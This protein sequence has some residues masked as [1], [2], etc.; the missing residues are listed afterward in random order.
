MRMYARHKVNSVF[1]S[2]LLLLLLT[3]CTSLAAPSSIESQQNASRDADARVAS[4]PVL[5]GQRYFDL[6]TAGEFEQA[7]EMWGPD[8][9]IHQSGS[10]RFEQSMLAY[11]AFHGE[12]TGEARTEGAAGTLYAEVPIRVSGARRGEP[13]SNDGTMTLQRCNDVPGC[14]E[15]Q[16]RWR[17]D[18]IDLEQK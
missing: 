3:S 12:M 7:Y 17:L 16:R 18:S 1:C 8:T 5:T 4:D 11:Q 13:F 10:R 6:L 15:E 9:P 2:A 14:S